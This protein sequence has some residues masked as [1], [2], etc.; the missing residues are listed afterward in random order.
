MPHLVHALIRLA[1]LYAV[2]YAVC[3]G[4]EGAMR[5]KHGVGSV[6]AIETLHSK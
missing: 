5:L 6:T 4:I 1:I 2:S 3:I